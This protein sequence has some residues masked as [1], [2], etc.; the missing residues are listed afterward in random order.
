MIE[1]M[2]HVA[3]IERWEMHIGHNFTVFYIGM[4]RGPEHLGKNV[5]YIEGDWQ[6]GAERN[7]WTQEKKT[8][9]RIKYDN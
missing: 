8:R 6:Q 7:I 3:G 1:R 9:G 4:K 2:R 5:H